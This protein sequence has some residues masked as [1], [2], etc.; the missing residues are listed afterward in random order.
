MSKQTSA[1]GKEVTIRV[2]QL[3][4]KKKKK[5]EQVFK[6]FIEQGSLLRLSTRPL[7][8]AEHDSAL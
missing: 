4:E 8:R 6:C 2:E 1:K 3:N 5:N 7:I